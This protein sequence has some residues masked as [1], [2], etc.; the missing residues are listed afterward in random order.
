[1]VAS[2]SATLLIVIIFFGIW[3]LIQQPM[4]G[5]LH[6]LWVLL[7]YCPY[8][9]GITVL[10]NP[11]PTVLPLTLSPSPWDYRDLRPHY[12]NFTAVIA[13]FPL[14]PSPCSSLV[15]VCSTIWSMTDS[16]ISFVWQSRTRLS[17][18]VRNDQRLTRT[19]SAVTLS[20]LFAISSGTLSSS[21]SGSFFYRRETRQQ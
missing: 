12:C 4:S 11:I 13:V 10:S 3:L 20:R 16:Q 1:M 15:C 5:M 9:L 8:S 6:E 21:P 19:L 18:P 2:S 7:S 14:S 17:H